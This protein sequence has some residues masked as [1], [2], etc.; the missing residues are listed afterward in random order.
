MRKKI[1]QNWVK[2]VQQ[3][4][5][6][7]LVMLMCVPTS[8]SPIKAAETG[9]NV[10]L[11]IPEEGGAIYFS[12]EDK[13]T[14]EKEI[15]PGEQVTVEFT[16]KDDYKLMGLSVGAVD[17]AEFTY[18][19]T[20]NMI[21]FVMPDTDVSINVGTLSNKALPK[22][23][24]I[25]RS[26][27]ASSPIMGNAIAGTG[28]RVSGALDPESGFITAFWRD[29]TG[30]ITVD[31][32]MALCIQPLQMDF[33]GN[34]WTEN[35]TSSLAKK[36][37]NIQWY[38][39]EQTDRSDWNR[40]VAQ[41]MTWDE[42]GYTFKLDNSDFNNYYN[43]RKAEVKAMI[44]SKPDEITTTGV[45]YRSTQGQDV[46]RLSNTLAQGEFTAVKLS[47]SPDCTDGNP[48]YDLTGAEYMLYTDAGAKTPVTPT[49][50]TLPL[51]TKA[52]GTMNTIGVRSG[53]YYLKE[54]K[55][56][57]AGFGIN[58]NVVKVN[59]SPGKLTTIRL[60]GDNAE[61][62]MFD[63]INVMVQKAVTEMDNAGQANG[64]ISNFAGAEFKF[65]Y[66]SGLYETAAEAKASGNPKASAIWT[67]HSD[68]RIIFGN[69]N[70]TSGTWP[71]R[72]IIDMNTVPLGT[73][74][75]DEVKGIPGTITS[76]IGRV[77]Q[78]V[79]SGDH[80]TMIKIVKEAWGGN[81]N[82]AVMA[83]DNVSYKGGVT[84][85]KADD[86]TK[87]SKP[88]GDA[89][90]ANVTYSIYNRSTN[91]VRALV[92][93][94]W[95][96]TAVNGK[97]MDIKT[98]YDATNKR[99]VATTGVKV[100]PYGDYEAIE[101]NPSTGYHNNEWKQSFTIK[102]DG[103]MLSY[104][105]ATTNWNT[106]DVNRY[107]VVIGKMDRDGDQYLPL[108][109]ASLEGVTF[110]VVNKSK[111]NVVVDGKT[112]APNGVVGT[113]ATKKEV[114]GD[115]AIQYVA[116]SASNW[117]PYG[118]YAVTELNSGNGYLY[119]DASKA[120]SKT[121]SVGYDGGKDAFT[122]TV[123]GYA[124]L[125][126]HEH[127]AKNKV[128]RNNW[129]F[130]KKLLDNGSGNNIGARIPFVITS[131]TTGE[132]H[133][134]VTDDNGVWG[135]AWYNNTTKTNSNDPDS[136][137]SNG[138]IGI[139]GDGNYYVKDESK[140]N[141]EVGTWFTGASPAVTTWAN[142]MKSYMINGNKVSVSDALASFP[143]DAYSME[144]LRVSINE[145]YF[146]LTTDVNLHYKDGHDFDYGTL[147]NRQ[148]AQP[149]I[150]TVLTYGKTG[151]IGKIA[152]AAEKVTLIDRVSY[153]NL[154]LNEDYVLKGELHY[155]N[156]DGK[157]TGAI[158]KA[159]LPFRASGVGNGNAEVVFANVDTRAYG[160]GYLVA[161]EYLY[162]D[163][164]K[165]VE[166]VDIKDENQMIYVPTIKTTLLGH[167]GHEGDASRDV[168]TLLDTITYTNLEPGKNYVVT[169]TLHTQA[170][171]K[172][173]VI[174]DGGALLD[175]EGNEIIATTTFSPSEATGSVEVAFTFRGVDIAGKNLVAF[176]QISL[177]DVVFA[178]H[179]DIQD[180]GQTVSFINVK[181]KASDIVDNDNEI[182]ADKNQSIV[183][184]ITLNNLTIG[185]E[186][187]VTGTLHV[188]SKNNA[189]VN[190]DGGV[191][192][193]SDGTDVAAKATFIAKKT[194]EE[195]KLTFKFDASK[196]AGK[197][198]VVFERVSRGDIVLGTHADINDEAQTI[199]VPKIS[200]AMVD[201]VGSSF[202]DLDNMDENGIVTLVDTIS[203]EN[204]QVGKTYEAQG[205]LH[206]RNIDKDG[207]ISDGGVLVVDG[208][209]ITAT[210]KFTP[211][212]AN[213]LVDVT[214]TFNA[215]DMEA[216]SVVAFEI[217]S[218]VHTDG[219]K[220]NVAKHE[221]IDDS[222]QTIQFG[223]IGTSII[224]ETSESQMLEYQEKPIIQMEEL[225]SET[226][227][228]GEV[229]SPTKNEVTLIDTVSYTG[230]TIGKT[231][232]VNGTLH[233]AVLEERVA[234]DETTDEPT[235]DETIMTRGAGPIDGDTN[236]DGVVDENDKDVPDKD[237]TT[238]KDETVDNEM[239]VRDG[240]ILTD[241]DG[242]EVHASATF[243]AESVD[244]SVDVKFTFTLGA[245][246]DNTRLVAFEE[247]VDDN[248]VIMTH[249]DI[250]DEGQS[251]YVLNMATKAMSATGEKVIA[252][253]EEV[254]VIDT[255]V[256]ENLVV[257]QEYNVLGTLMLKDGEGGSS[258]ALDSNGD[259]V[260]SSLTF[261]PETTSGTVEMKFIVDTR[262]L[263]EKSLVAF[264]RM[265]TAN[266]T[267]I[268]VHEDI[269]DE[270]QSV[271]VD[272]AVPQVEV[273]LET[274]I[275]MA[276]IGLALLGGLGAIGGTLAYRKRQQKEKK[277]K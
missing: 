242:K 210:T 276:Y 10:Y 37:G 194:T 107:G 75:I 18:E 149:E 186:Y 234:E 52:D 259:A 164:A 68:G 25:G 185:K 44:A 166:H 224:S 119:D 42:L 179:A 134:V 241:R 111:N 106:N 102:T 57:A 203:Y 2:R 96:T 59:V 1:K 209:D 204:L 268:G 196:L 172:D 88:Q 143:Y 50:G 237:E 208:K 178:T 177:D 249:A 235:S 120:W 243:V 202:I 131:K 140:L 23:K 248:I 146:M 160:E 145:D 192:K 60:T 87:L 29:G 245:D 9:P 43:T 90:L 260:V 64:N 121:F 8:L 86:D 113:I 124:D 74:V 70:P 152:P 104:E 109:G 257:G 197:D 174:S 54:T 76:G 51:V 30:T 238:D 35:M 222:K 97:V 15:K 21:T 122:T 154:K 266:G 6:V 206:S 218:A 114:L 213:G 182:I 263:H 56:P 175:G 3:I 69:D 195:V 153:N 53:T 150:G 81:K 129:N 165:I 4:G 66:Y 180:K 72:D 176:E 103:Q 171:G 230:L 130:Q 191:L 101:S 144:E 118:N 26:T 63:P 148:E 62:A 167:D 112:I 28:A 16:I 41:Y 39:Y 227:D 189:G 199:H 110:E 228:D 277:S 212:S 223:R 190:Q 215:H 133:V 31:G 38:A 159:E 141:P 231:Y 161:F 214:F 217:V 207:K 264:E 229:M 211:K 108:G 89:D 156:K 173:G 91:P 253:A 33:A 270:H 61:P 201:K 13:E 155:V 254:E 49:S 14:Q 219:K 139:D 147:N 151:E 184:T 85:V 47:D 188:R 24:K 136:P 98:V 55:A 256:Y 251:M 205:V 262:D 269:N 46:V 67:T 22:D 132:K 5:S 261:T 12:G 226:T 11:S 99:Y 247:L 19:Q 244:G 128:S 157:D 200:T 123:G 265:S 239:V 158:A 117:L 163:G 252:A 271:T 71:Y 135:S 17:N 105:T 45:I 93:G 73:L 255:I 82:D 100:L 78:F 275:P 34:Y 94:V 225:D 216:N 20:D 183:D 36:L 92:N 126:S 48:A 169:G 170:I 221:A 65:S 95:T 127:A 250:E 116:R 80:I 246:F 7:F 77:V 142:D 115:G 125:R 198:V 240:G 193:N 79:D 220:S 187:T 84:I 83:F 58:S 181:T 138:A 232:H 236:H 273:T 32:D 40:A 272:K 27:R 274:G 267:V 137:N 162:K 233:K 168:I 258:V